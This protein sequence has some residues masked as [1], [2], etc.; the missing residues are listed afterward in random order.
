[1]K[2]TIGR[3]V[4]YVIPKSIPPATV[5]GPEKIVAGEERPA[6]IVRTWG[7]DSVNLQVFSDGA[8]DHNAALANG[9]WV[10]SVSLDEKKGPRTWHWPER[11]EEQS[12]PIVIVEELAAT[13]EPALAAELEPEPADDV[14]IHD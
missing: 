13:P 9:G 8:N 14:L 5:G 12:T 3:I 1:M 11:D 4:H 10:T 6:M 7:G 2:P